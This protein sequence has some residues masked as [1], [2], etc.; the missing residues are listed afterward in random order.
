[1]DGEVG[2]EGTVDGE[3]YLAFWGEKVSKFGLNNI[4]SDGW[5]QIGFD[6]EL[7]MLDIP[8]VEE[9]TIILTILI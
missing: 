4:V 9:N 8:V 2:D 5:G 7:I 1:M 6:E 3:F